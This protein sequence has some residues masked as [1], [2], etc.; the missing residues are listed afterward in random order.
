M[1]SHEFDKILSRIERCEMELQSARAYIKALEQGLHTAI[2]THSDPLRMG[3]L[4]G[5]VLVE[6]AETHAGAPGATPVFHATFQSA[7][8]G[9]SAHVE[10]AVDRCKMKKRDQRL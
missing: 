7:L 4:W 3:E 5:H 9:I 8:A 6:V 10:D 2:M 1:D